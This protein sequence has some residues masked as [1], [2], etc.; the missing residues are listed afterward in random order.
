[1]KILVFF[2]KFCFKVQKKKKLFQVNVLRWNMLLAE[3]CEAAICKWEK[4][5]QLLDLSHT[6]WVISLYDDF[7]QTYFSW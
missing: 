7:F 5:Q 3:R 6:K 1:M 2:S 4:S